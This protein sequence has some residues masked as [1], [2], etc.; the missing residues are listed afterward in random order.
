MGGGA[1]TATAVSQRPARRTDPSPS[2]LP[3]SFF[4]RGAEIRV[5]VDDVDRAPVDTEGPGLQRNPALTDS[6]NVGFAQ[7]VDRGRLRLRVYER[8]VG[9]TLACGS[10]ACAAA[11]VAM[12]RG[13][14]DRTVDVE[15][16]GGTLRIDWPHDDATIAMTGPAAFVFE[17]EWIE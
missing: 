6:V 8:G 7:V 9:E 14:V 12:R 2:T 4:G 13:W 10:G 17:G 16:P 11:V 15:L 1:E 5:R 3:K